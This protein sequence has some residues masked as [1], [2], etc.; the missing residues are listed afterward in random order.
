MKLSEIPYQHPNVEMLGQRIQELCTQFE[1]AKS[2]ALQLKIADQMNEIQLE[3]YTAFNLVRIRHNGNSLDEFYEKEITF[4]YRQMPVF[5][6]ISNRYY[7]ALLDSPFQTEL[8]QKLGKRLFEIAKVYTTEGNPQTEL[9]DQKINRLS[10]TYDRLIAQ[11]KFSFEGE[12]YPLGAIGKFKQSEN[13]QTRKTAYDAFYNFWELKAEELHESFGKL[14]ALRVEK[15]QALGFEDYI[16]AS[17]DSYGYNSHQVSNFN[18]AVLKH[19]IP[20]KKRLYERRLKRLGVEKVQ[21]Y[22]SSQYKHGNPKLHAESEELWSK[23]QKMYTELSPETDEFCRFMLENQLLDTAPRKGKAQ[24]AYMAFL[25]K[26][27]QPFIFANFW[28][29]HHDFNTLTHE[30]GHAFQYFQTKK[31][32]ILQMEYE[33]PTRDTSETHA[34]SMELFTWDWYSLF[35]K[36][37]TAKYQFSKISGMLDTIVSCCLNEDFQQFIYKNPHITPS[38]RNQKWLGLKKTYYP[39]NPDSF[40]EENTY[41]KEGH[42]WLM[43]SHIFCRPFYA[44][45]YSL[46]TLCAIQFWMKAKENKKE[47][48]RDYLRLCKV[49]G[50]YSFFES[51]QLANLRSPFDETVI[52]EIAQ[53]LGDWLEKVDDS[54]F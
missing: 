16:E 49:G 37:D 24:M 46:A 5:D 42:N 22:D 4:F 30:M 41:L 18:K 3:F 27:Q 26:Y 25:G 45:A 52:Q 40:Y 13:P 29:T 7:Q 32:G 6:N 43:N 53:F 51:L 50:K 35:F 54:G 23:T 15:A 48:W 31:E 14:V 17:Y 47:A 28:G 21:Y 10:G 9:I 19:F 33:M 38:Q 20:L 36:E 44:I 34:I 2:P 39:Y 11:G 8:K 1:N 12:D